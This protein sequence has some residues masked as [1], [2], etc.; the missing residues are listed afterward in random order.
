MSNRWKVNLDPLVSWWLCA[1]MVN[2]QFIRRFRN[3]GTLIW[4]CGMIEWRKEWRL[5]GQI[6]RHHR[7]YRSSILIWSF[8]SFSVFKRDC[9]SD[10][11][12]KYFKLCYVG[13]EG[14]SHLPR[15]TGWTKIVSVWC[16]SMDM[17]DKRGQKLYNMKLNRKET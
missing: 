5:M 14:R 3:S 4:R 2:F 7:V 15:A 10:N 1:S 8:V 17:H 9:E 11:V 6:R 16:S 13:G 12:K